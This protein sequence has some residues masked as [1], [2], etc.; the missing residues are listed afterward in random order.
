MSWQALEH[1]FQIGP[2]IVPVELGRLHQAHHD[3]GA[4]AGQFAAAKKPGLPTHCPGAHQVLD[5]VVV[6]RHT[7]VFQVRGERLPVVQAVVD[8]RGNGTA[9]GKNQY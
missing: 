6:D 1:V 5:V 4:L 7:P 8:G 2:R 9:V 3:G